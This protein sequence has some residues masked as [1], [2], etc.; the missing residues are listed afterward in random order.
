MQVET[1]EVPLSAAQHRL[2]TWFEQEYL[3]HESIPSRERCVA[4]GACT[5]SFYDSCFKSQSFLNALERRGIKLPSF[6]KNDGFPVG[7]LTEHQLIVA[8]AMLDLTDNRSRKKKLAELRVPS[9]TYEA[10]LRDP[11]YRNYIQ[12]RAENLLPDNQQDAHLALLDRVRSGDISAIK[13][14]NEIT[15]RYIPNTTDKVDVNAILMRVLEVIQRHVS[16]PEA[17]NGIA[18]ELLALSTAP[19]ITGRA[20]TFR[21]PLG[22]T[23]EG[24]LVSKGA[25]TSNGAGSRKAITGDI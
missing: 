22:E 15:G 25:G 10:W 8:N 13:Y 12:A 24:S 20:P 9:Q 21:D 17:L 6:L 18:E 5:K 16:E 11:A 14:F 2:L 23:V 3:L 7:A 4:E 19:A 1:K